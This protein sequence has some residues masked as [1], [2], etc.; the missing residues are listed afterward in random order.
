MMF[1]DRGIIGAV[2]RDSD[3]MKFALTTSGG[4]KQFFMNDYR[5]L[6]EMI[7]SPMFLSIYMG[8]RRS[9]PMMLGPMEI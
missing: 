7:P 8:G 4:H 1:F 3:L 9:K 5:M 6:L 2:I